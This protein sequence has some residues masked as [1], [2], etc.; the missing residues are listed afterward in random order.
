MCCT[1]H[2]L[3]RRRRRR[4]LGRRNQRKA[5]RTRKRKVLIPIHRQLTRQGRNAIRR[6][7]EEPTRIRKTKV[8][9][10]K[11]RQSMNRRSWTQKRR[12][13]KRKKSKWRTRLWQLLGGA[14]GIDGTRDLFQLSSCMHT[15]SIFQ[16][17]RTETR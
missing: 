5:T 12:P 10:Q 4:T 1:D 14:H 6:K 13:R 8:K 2:Q 3:R 16:P 7:S 17:S 15:M 11:R 9:R